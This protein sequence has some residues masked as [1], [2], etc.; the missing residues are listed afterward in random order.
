MAVERDRAIWLHYGEKQ[1]DLVI[2]R[3]H[4]IWSKFDMEMVTFTKMNPDILGV[5]PLVDHMHEWDKDEL[6]GPSHCRSY[7]TY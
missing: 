1:A 5:A 7:R 4:I 3:E 2:Q 6:A